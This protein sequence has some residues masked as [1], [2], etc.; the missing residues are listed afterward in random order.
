MRFL[1][2]GFFM[3]QFPLGSMYLDGSIPNFYE[4]S[5]SFCNFGLIASINDTSDKLFTGVNDTSNKL[6]TL[7]LLVAT[8]YF[9][10]Y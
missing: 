3:K 4:N 6:S 8:N 10:G 7:G 9:Q 1:T 5:R 2:S